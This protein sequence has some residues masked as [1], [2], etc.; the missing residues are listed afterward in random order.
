MPA[1]VDGLASGTAAATAATRSKRKLSPPSR[2]PQSVSCAPEAI[3]E[4]QLLH[5]VLE[6]SLLLGPAMNPAQQLPP[7]A[8]LPGPGVPG[9]GTHARTRSTSTDYSGKTAVGSGSSR[10]ASVASGASTAVGANSPSKKRK[11]LEEEDVDLLDGD[12]LGAL[13]VEGDDDSETVSVAAGRAKR[14][15]KVNVPSSVDDAITLSEKG[16]VAKATTVPR[17]SRKKARKA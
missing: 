15:R 8:H 3:L 7:M 11:A 16:K 12:L 13:E 10:S 2:Y 4:H 14:S 17:A 9:H 1:E 5:P 6:A